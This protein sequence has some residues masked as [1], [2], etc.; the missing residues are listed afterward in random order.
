MTMD[1]SAANIITPK[2]QLYDSPFSSYD[3]QLAQNASRITMSVANKSYRPRVESGKVMHLGN[4]N[5]VR[6]YPNSDAYLRKDREGYIGPLGNVM[7][8]TPVD[9][10]HEWDGYNT[11]YRHETRRVTDDLQVAQKRVR[12]YTDQLNKMKEERKAVIEILNEV[13]R[14]QKE[15]ESKKGNGGTLL[16]VDFDT[17]QSSSPATRNKMV[18]EEYSP[19]KKYSIAYGE[20]ESFSKPSTTTIIVIVVVI[21]LVLILLFIVYRKYRMRCLSKQSKVGY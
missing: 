17:K 5:T 21:I 13:E 2:I 19:T 6:S 18:A 15:K 10:K 14:K 3:S 7:P 1:L 20:R 11:R 8:D 16:G 12:T 9:I 4:E